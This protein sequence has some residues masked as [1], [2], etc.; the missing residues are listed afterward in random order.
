MG[1][2]RGLLEERLAIA[3]DVNDA[4]GNVRVGISPHAPYSV[5]S[6]GYRRCLEVAKQKNLP[7]ATNLA[8]S[9]DEAEF[10]ARHSGSL[11]K[12]W[13]FVGGFDEAVTKFEGGR[14]DR[15]ISL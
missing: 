14:S 10:L 13:D 2:R 4:A 15:V 7:L 3:G 8:E 1:Q 6:A 12:V 9:A 5:E 11:M